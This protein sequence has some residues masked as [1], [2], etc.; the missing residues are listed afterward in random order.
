[1]S[2]SLHCIGL[3]LAHPSIVVV[4]AEALDEHG[5]EPE[6]AELL[7]TEGRLSAGKLTVWSAVPRCTG[8]AVAIFSRGRQ[9]SWFPPRQ[10]N[11]VIV[12]E[13]RGISPYMEPFPGTSSLLYQ[14][15]L[16]THPEYVAYMLVHVERLALL[17]S[18]RAALIY[19]LSYWFDRDDASRSAF[20]SAAA[21]AKRPDARCFTALADAFEWIDQLLHIPLREPQQEIGEPYLQVVERRRDCMRRAL[22]ATSHRTLQ[23]RRGSRQ[24][25]DSSHCTGGRARAFTH[26]RCAV[27][28]A[29]ADACPCD[30]RGARRHDGVVARDE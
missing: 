15:D 23:D 2:I 7:I 28:L 8:N 30:R 10:T 14:S 1:M 6:F 4:P 21:R 9:S 3:H 17:S 18:A 29:A 25:G 13:Q 24:Q 12:S 26:R 5:L 27:R 19:N 20:A 16:N 22:A 11:L